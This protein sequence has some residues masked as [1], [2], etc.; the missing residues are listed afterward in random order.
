MGEGAVQRRWR[1]WPELSWRAP[2][3]QRRPDDR[4][5]Q[6][7]A[8]QGGEVRETEGQSQ[9]A[10]AVRCRRAAAAALPLR[11]PSAP[12]SPLCPSSAPHRQ[13]KAKKDERRKRQD[14][15]AKAEELGLEPPP[16]QQ[17]RVRCLPALRCCSTGQRCAA[18]AL[19]CC[20]HCG[21]AATLNAAA[22]KQTWRCP[23]QQGGRPAHVG[24]N[25]TPGCSNSSADCR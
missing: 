11:R 25:S 21:A 4:T 18:L 1:G 10:F 9:G 8:G 12:S 2:G 22:A 24:I 16:R 5:H 3:A 14:E 17:Q 20:L 23:R 13:Q 6:E 7:Q 15:A 19:R